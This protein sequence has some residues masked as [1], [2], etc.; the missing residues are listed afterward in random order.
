MSAPT[1]TGARTALHFA[2]DLHG[3][4]QTVCVCQEHSKSLLA[5]RPLDTE[6]GEY[7]TPAEDDATCEYCPAEGGKS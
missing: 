4:S 6:F 5:Y 2:P 3:Y 7:A 1:T